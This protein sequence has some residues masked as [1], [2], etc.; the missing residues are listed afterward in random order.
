MVTPD[1]VK[2]YIAADLPCEH[3]EVEGDGQHFYATIVSAEFRGLTMVKQQQK[4]YGVL[5]DRMKA[6]IHA[7]SMKTYTPE[8]WAE[9]AK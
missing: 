8:R 4:V 2:N 9:M 6:E 7:L 5:G 3:I 1:M